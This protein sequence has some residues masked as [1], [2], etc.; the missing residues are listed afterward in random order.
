MFL[1]KAG[2]LGSLVPLRQESQDTE[3]HQDGGR[4]GAFLTPCPSH[5]YLK[6]RNWERWP[7]A[8]LLLLRFLKNIWNSLWIWYLFRIFSICCLLPFSFW[9]LSLFHC[10]KK[11]NKKGF[12]FADIMNRV[13]ADSRSAG[14]FSCISGKGVPFYTWLIPK[15]KCKLPVCSTCTWG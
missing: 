10:V 6:K 15:C 4:L 13:K 5:D 11:K 1:E 7:N 14:S 9:K 12:T 8:F 2:Y 3:H